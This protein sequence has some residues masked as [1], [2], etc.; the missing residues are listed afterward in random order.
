MEFLKAFGP[1][2]IPVIFA[3][4]IIREVFSFL[5]AR[6]I[7]KVSEEVHDQKQESTAHDEELVN[8]LKKINANIEAN[9]DLTRELCSRMRETERKVDGMRDEIDDLRGEVRKIRT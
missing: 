8:T 1:E 6:K 4:I 2:W 5:K 3:I 9:T 7:E